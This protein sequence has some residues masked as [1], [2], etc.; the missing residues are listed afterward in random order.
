MESYNREAT[1]HKGK[2][3]RITVNSLVTAPINRRHLSNLLQVLKDYECTHNHIESSPKM[4]FISLNI[5]S[6]LLMFA[7]NIIYV[8]FV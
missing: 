2:A 8:C 5:F 6:N 7:L 4:T 1:K 3:I